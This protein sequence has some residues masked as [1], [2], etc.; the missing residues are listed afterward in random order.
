MGVYDY[1]ATFWAMIACCTARS[2]ATRDAFAI[3]TNGWS[4]CVT[5]NQTHFIP[6]KV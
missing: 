6:Y 3:A 5:H 1:R 4:K 2:C